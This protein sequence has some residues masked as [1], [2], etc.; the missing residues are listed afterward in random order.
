MTYSLAVA[1]ST[2]LLVPWFFAVD[3]KLVAP[4]PSGDNAQASAQP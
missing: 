4:R 1:L 3:L 2:A